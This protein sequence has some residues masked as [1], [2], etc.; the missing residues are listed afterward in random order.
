M[1]F[2]KGKQCNIFISVSY[3][4]LLFTPFVH[5]QAP[6]TDSDSKSTRIQDLISKGIWNFISA[7][8]RWLYDYFSPGS[9]TEIGI[10]VT[11]EP[12]SVIQ[13]LFSLW[14]TSPD[15]TTTL[16]PVITHGVDHTPNVQVKKSRIKKKNTNNNKSL[17]DQMSA[18]EKR[19]KA[20]GVKI[21]QLQKD[22]NGP[23]GASDRN[24]L[25]TIELQAE[26][27][28]LFSEKAR[29]KNLIASQNVSEA[30]TSQGPVSGDETIIDSQGAF[31]D[32][33]KDYDYLTASERTEPLSGF[34]NPSRHENEP[35]KNEDDDDSW[36]NSP[37]QEL[38]A[39]VFTTT[40]VSID[41]RRSV[42]SETDRKYENEKPANDP[43]SF[44]GRNSDV[45]TTGANKG[46][47]KKRK[48][49]RTRL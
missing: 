43:E 16:S 40:A 24:R 5:S 4:I 2:R 15:I 36:M 35:R 3:L 18:N 38:D 11:T 6:P 9:E 23:E 31:S 12:P 41:N 44:Q 20:L 46:R 1:I 28:E 33:E 10:A 19:R 39:T 29:L 13:S 37:S 8:S 22:V 45:S 17:E 25:R 49:K 48:R 27:K 7:P 30:A 34:D 32:A 21:K 47:S 26:A 42:E 14:Y